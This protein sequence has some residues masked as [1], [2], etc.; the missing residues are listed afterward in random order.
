MIKTKLNNPKDKLVK[1]LN[2]Q[3]N[4]F[5]RI[6]KA[7]INGSFTIEEYDNEKEI[8]ESTIKNL[9]EKIKECNLCDELKF[10]PEDILIKR[11]LDYINQLIY[12]EEY[13]ENSYMWK[14]YDRSEKADLI[15]RYVDYVELEYYSNN[16]VRLG[17]VYFRESMC[18]PCNKLYDAGF[19]A[20]TDYA[21]LGNI[22]TKLR[23]SEY[24]PIEKVSEIVFTLRQYYNVGYFEATYYYDNKVMFFNDYENRNIVRIFPIEDYQKMNKLDKI[25]LGV[26][27]LGNDEKSLI[28]NKEDLF[29]TIPEKTNCRT[30]IFDKEEKKNDNVSQEQR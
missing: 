26:I 14:D 12:P 4:K 22:V 25:Q 20:R 19:L 9:E 6:R 8:V 18:K 13:E 1:E 24:L 30:F 17:E 23:F 10:T 27:Y 5:E 15:M 21:I 28:D 29:T 2:E 3:N 7:Y 11:D 16:K